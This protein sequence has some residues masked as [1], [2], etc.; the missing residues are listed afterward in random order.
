MIKKYTT[1]KRSFVFAPDNR[2]IRV[3]ENGRLSGLI[4]NCDR[5]IQVD[6]DEIKSSEFFK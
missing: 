5:K 6:G 3:Y 1:K 4:W 2:Y